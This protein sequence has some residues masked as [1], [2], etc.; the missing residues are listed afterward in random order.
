[1][2]TDIEGV[3]TMALGVILLCMYVVSNIH[4]VCMHVCKYIC[5]YVIPIFLREW[6]HREGK[7]SLGLGSLVP[8]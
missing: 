8:I 5:N 4:V 2:A 1:M 7:G 3:M 6:G